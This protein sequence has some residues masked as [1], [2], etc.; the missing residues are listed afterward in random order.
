MGYP[1]ADVALA[2]PCD[3]L[4]EGQRIYQAETSH[5]RLAGACRILDIRALTTIRKGKNDDRTGRMQV[6]ALA[7]AGARPFIDVKHRYQE[8][9]P[10]IS[11][12]V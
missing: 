8:V 6:L 4:F 10:S 1:R 11:V 9:S 5:R 2:R 3:G 12:G 7:H